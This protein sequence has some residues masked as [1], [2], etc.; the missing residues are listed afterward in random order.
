[1]RIAN[2]IQMNDWDIRKFLKVILAIQLVLWGLIGL[3]AIGI[4]VLIARQLVG[5][6]Y[7]TFVPGVILLR[8]L[9]IHKIGNIETILYMVGLSI[10]ILMFTGASMNA[11][12]PLLGI[13]G[14]ISTIPLVITIGAIVL[15]LCVICYIID[16]DFQN[17][18]F[19]DLKDLLSPPVLFLCLIPLLVIIGTYAVN[20]YHTNIILLTMVALIPII[21][22]LIGLDLFISNKM[23]PFAVLLIAISLVFHNSLIS[24]YVWGYDINIEL[25]LSSLV[26][27]NSIWDPTLPLTCNGMLSLVTLA[28][29]YSIISDMSLTWVFKIIYPLIFSL[30]PLGLYRVFQMQSDDGIAFVSCLFFMSLN[31]FYT[32]MLQLARQEIA[33]LF[34]VLLI[35]LM[36]NKIIAKPKRS[37]LLIIFS[38]SLAVSHYGLS[39]IFML[40]LIIAWI[41]LVLV[42]N[43]KIQRLANSYLSNLRKGVGYTAF[44]PNLLNSDRS[45]NL[46]FVLLFVTFTLM[47]YIS[48]SDSASFESIT[49]IG[50]HIID[51]ISTNFLDPDSAQGLKLATTKSV[52]GLL[53]DI[54]KVMNYLNQIFIVIGGIVLLLKSQAIRFEREYIAFSELNL[55]LCFVGVS[56][57]FFA[58]ALNM[59]RLYQITL[60]FLAPICV[61]G[62][63]A[64]IRGIFKLARIS[65][66]DNNMAISIKILSVYFAIFLLY[67]SGI[68]FGLTEG[69]S[70]P[71]LVY[72]G[73]IDFP[74]FNDRE[75]SGALWWIRNTNANDTIFV[76]SYRSQ[77]FNGIAWDRLADSEVDASYVYLGT[78]NIMTG[79]VMRYYIEKANRLQS[80]S[81]YASLIDRKSMVYS[82]GGSSIYSR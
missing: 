46:A 20:F 1:M 18:N 68:V 59:T 60:I 58:S 19:M 63:I 32:E 48:V 21:A 43:L 28:P 74:R 29:I 33:E 3:D 71:F 55:G 78:F 5:F 39:Y 65:W 25:Y 61:I 36:I 64:V 81:S 50:M 47:W 22:A 14:P 26:K 16:R 66:T 37:F 17:P 62:G 11:L 52:P 7:L 6:T 42:E 44:N 80:Y 13:S 57:P 77:L 9:K 2:P 70:G 4:H 41:M 40:C 73:T 51:S 75:V 45:F 54:N 10:A 27:I 76:D 30:V 12:F 69:F 53:H 15:I 8:I 24:M 34:L 82:D 56:V 72:N 67:Q 35:L 79:Y 49:R 23:F 38:I 31:V